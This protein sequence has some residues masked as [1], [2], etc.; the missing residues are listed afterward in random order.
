MITLQVAAGYHVNANPASLEFLIPT[1][2]QFSGPPPRQVVY[3]PAGTFQPAFADEALRVYE[4]E[5]VI[6]AVFESPDAARAAGAAATVTVQA[7]NDTVCYPP[8]QIA[9]QAR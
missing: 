7:C 1:R 9:V 5:A 2:V 8:A 3:P 6:A 4:G